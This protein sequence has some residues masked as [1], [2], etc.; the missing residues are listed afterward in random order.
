LQDRV[1]IRLPGRKV[2][3]KTSTEQE[4]QY[5]TKGVQ[6]KE[7]LG[8]TDTEICGQTEYRRRKD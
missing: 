6:N 5:K 8:K 2:Q 1:R 4:N 7:L 3:Y